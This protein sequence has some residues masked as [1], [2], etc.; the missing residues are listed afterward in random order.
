MFDKLFNKK[1]LEEQIELLQTRINELEIENKSLSGRL[2]KQD[3]R[4]KKAISDKQTVDEALNKA[5]KKIKVLEHDLQNLKEHSSD[6]LSF[7]KSTTLTKSRSC[8]LLFQIGSIRSKNENLLTIYLSPDESISDLIEF[9]GFLDLDKDVKYL[10]NKI[11][12]P[13][14]IALFYDMNPIGGVSLIVAPP[15]PIG[16]TKWKLNSQ[17]DITSV[18][19]ILTSD[20]AISIIL[21]HAGETFIGI[22]NQEKFID[23]KVVHS[24]V[25]EKHTKGGFSQRRF[26][27]LR[28]EDIKHHTDKAKEAFEVLMNEYESENTNKNENEIGMV[29]AGGEHGLV[30]AITKDCPY[31]VF[32]KNIDIKVDKHNIDRIRIA[33]WSSVWFEL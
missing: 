7:K 8:D 33:V 21:A 17:F 28:D 19:E 9:E 10:V 30:G 24:N 31:P 5:E 23:Y 25:K 2:L 16:E 3:T 1:E 20:R 32:L 26:E 12:S 29:V 14:G 27:R 6:E 18:Q 11:R 13:T 15:F 22:S 4:S